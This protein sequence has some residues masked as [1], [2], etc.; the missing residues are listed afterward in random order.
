MIREPGQ[1][2]LSIKAKMPKQQPE[3]GKVFK[4]ENTDCREKQLSAC[5]LQKKRKVLKV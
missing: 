5:F 4:C 3:A 2:P 1:M